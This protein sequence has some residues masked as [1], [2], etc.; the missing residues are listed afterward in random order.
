MIEVVRQADAEAER[1]MIAMALGRF[2]EYWMA[3]YEAARQRFEK[4]YNELMVEDGSEGP[5]PG[6]QGEGG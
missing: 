3:Q 6:A 5:V 1:A 2:P 4:A